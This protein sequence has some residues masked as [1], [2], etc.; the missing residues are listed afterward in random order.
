VH[1]PVRA[2]SEIAIVVVTEDGEASDSWTTDVLPVTVRAISSS[3]PA[4][5]AELLAQPKA[6]RKWSLFT[7][8]N[9]AGRR[10]VRG[11]MA[12]AGDAAHPVLPFLAQGGVLAL[13]DALVMGQCVGERP[14]D[15][16]GAFAQYESR[17]R[18]R[19]AR[20]ARASRSN[21]AIYHMSGLGAW[22]RNSVLRTASPE[23]LMQRYDWLYGWRV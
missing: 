17:R 14:D 19:A 21:G 6:W 2:G 18:A 8:P 22:A 13:E 4:R 5:L 3:F 12:L 23:R 16:A 11:R 9:A 1:Y 20:V 15:I 10:W 7:L